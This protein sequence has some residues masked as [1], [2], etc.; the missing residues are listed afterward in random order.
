MKFG[1]EL[2]LTAAIAHAHHDH[3]GSFYDYVLQLMRESSITNWRMDE[4]AS[5]GNEFVS[6]PLEGE[7]GWAQ[8]EQVIHCVKTA[9]E[10]FG[11]KRIIGNDSGVHYHF[12]ANDLLKL[13]NRSVTALRNVLI[14]GAIL[15]PLWFSMNPAARFDTN[16]A[17]PLNFNMFQMIRARDMTDLRDIW[18]R[19]Y[20]GVSGHQDS[21]RVKNSLYLPD[22]VNNP[23]A[24]P[25]KYD[26]TRY[27]GLN[28]LSLFKHGTVE[29]RYTHGSF[30]SNN[31][32]LWYEM[33]RRVVEA[34]REMRTKNILL[35]SPVNFETLKASAIPN[36]Q[37]PLYADLKL[38]IDFL[39]K[40][41]KPDVKMLR[42]VLGK[43]IK[44]NPAALPK[45][46]VLKILD[47]HGDFDGLMALIT[48]TNIE[49]I[50]YKKNKY[51]YSPP[52]NLLA[53]TN[54]GAPPVEYEHAAI[55]PPFE[56]GFEEDSEP[57]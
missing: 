53:Q 18:F 26:W 30:D 22:F 36:L 1:I 5:C 14:L 31:I 52:H 32:T 13:S 42:F 11:Y 16:F 3:H 46:I 15:E 33:Y 40:V 50:H 47:Y 43:I 4:D 20:Q 19:P 49:S 12:D 35:S 37:A 21:Y 44:Y 10:V 57:D 56:D 51:R 48:P 39:F 23:A 17:A 24:K 7:K 41:I 25:D 45:N 54:T 55:D 28:F 34:A 8:V 2:E 6:P 38:V 27:H 9:Q 29:F